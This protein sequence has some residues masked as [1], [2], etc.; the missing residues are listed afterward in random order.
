[1]RGARLVPLILDCVA[2]NNHTETVKVLLAAGADKTIKSNTGK[3]ALDVAKTDE[4]KQLLQAERR[5]VHVEL[6]VMCCA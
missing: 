3:T 4:I 6:R 1:M 2:L 5:V